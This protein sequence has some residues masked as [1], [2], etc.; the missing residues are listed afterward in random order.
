MDKA[1][2]IKLAMVLRNSY[3]RKEW[4]KTSL[5]GLIIISH[6]RKISGVITLLALIHQLRKA[7]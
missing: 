3:I 2:Q 1:I 4:F 5:I 6:W 7:H